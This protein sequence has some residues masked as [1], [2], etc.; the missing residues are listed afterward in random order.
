[1]SSDIFWQKI[2]IVFENDYFC[3]ELFF[4]DIYNLIY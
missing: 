3:H 1:M 2:A 4:H